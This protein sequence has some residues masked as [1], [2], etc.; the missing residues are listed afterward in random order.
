MKKGNIFGRFGRFNEA[1]LCYDD[2]LLQE[3]EN[4]LAL[5]NKGLCHHN[6]G[7]YDIA[8]TCFNLVLKIKPQNKTAL[9]NKSSSIIK[10]GKIKEGLEILSELIKLDY[11]YK[12]QA[13]YDVDFV[14]IKLLNEFKEIIS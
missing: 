2:V 6:T 3:K 9:Y 7:Q 10:S 1:I 4:L 13:K 12:E 14:D 8:I 5:L 11:S